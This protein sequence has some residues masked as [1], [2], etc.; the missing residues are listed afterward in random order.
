VSAVQ[1]FLN[2]K[3][4]DVRAA[5]RYSLASRFDMTGNRRVFACRTSRVSPFQMLVAAPVL[6]PLGERVISHFGEFGK[7]DGWISDTIEN[8]FLIDL[9]VTGDQRA[10]LADKLEWLEKRQN[11]P[12]VI[13]VRKQQR[14]IPEDPHTTLLLADGTAL[15]C[16]AIDVSPSGAAV[17][18]DIEVEIGTR[19]A[20]GRTVG[21]VVRRFDEGFAVRFDDLQNPAKLEE[22]IRPTSALTFAA[23]SFRT[24]QANRSART[25]R[26]SPAP[27]Q[28]GNAS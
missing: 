18:A 5:G 11:D 4:V 20:V 28:Y 23:H 22:A 24:W 2:Q 12:S 13:D 8:G 14:V 16:F 19:L 25:L 15:T 27:A 26:E 21:Q 3:A 1:D 7:L 17:S 10:K 6:A 9:N